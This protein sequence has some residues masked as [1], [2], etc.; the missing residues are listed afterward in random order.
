ME[1]GFP[2]MRPISL[3]TRLPT[4][5]LRMRVLQISLPGGLTAG[6]RLIQ[7]DIQSND[8]GLKGPA[9]VPPRGGKGCVVPGIKSEQL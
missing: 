2:L 6:R 7:E 4:E 8:P 9:L 3:L 5:Y 1:S